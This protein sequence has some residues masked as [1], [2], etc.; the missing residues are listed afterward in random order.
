M[1]NKRILIPARMES[2]R[3][4]GK[5]LA[6]IGDRP[7]IKHVYDQALKT[8]CPV[9]V[10]TDSN[11]IKS[12][13]PDIDVIITPPANTGTDRIASVVDQFDEDILINC[14]GDLPFIDPQQIL[15]AAL[16]LD[17]HEVG[18][19]IFDMDENAQQNPN[20]VKAICSNMEGNQYRC[21]WFTRSSLKY[22]F[23]HA[24]IYAYSRFALK[25]LRR[26]RAYMES[27][28]D[29]EQLRFIEQGMRI[30]AMRTYHIYGEVNT[31]ADL[32]LARRYY[33]SR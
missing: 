5:P 18:T 27:L 30:G 11:D 7:L 1:L 15:T 4:P 26:S 10:L 20:T 19:L 13:L 2:Q 12:A 22:G 17:S 24:G 25:Y 29:L 9:T 8:G 23:T 21:H 16:P 31:P 28:E 6:M 3:L 32:E 33:E 14:Q